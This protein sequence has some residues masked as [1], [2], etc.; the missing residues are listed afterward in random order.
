MIGLVVNLS[1]GYRTVCNLLGG[2]G[3]VLDRVGVDRAVL[4]FTEPTA[5]G[6]MLSAVMVSVA[7]CPS[8][9][10]V[11]ECFSILVPSIELFI[12]FE[13]SILS[14]GSVRMPASISSGTVTLRVSLA[15]TSATA[16]TSARRYVS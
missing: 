9:P 4:Q 11:I 1:R 6:A 7:M 10:P 13:P 5:P 15:D 16:A 14:A 8:G 3:F 12:I 2:D